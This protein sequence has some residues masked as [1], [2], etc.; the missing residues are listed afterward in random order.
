MVQFRVL[1][2]TLS[3]SSHVTLPELD[4]FNRIYP[5]AIIDSNCNTFLNGILSWADIDRNG[6]RFFP[7]SPI[8]KEMKDEGNDSRNAGSRG[9][10]I[11]LIKCI[12]HTK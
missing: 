9:I 5:W 3:F 12:V 6:N 11:L 1:E 7:D 10:T 2:L 4:L 8:E